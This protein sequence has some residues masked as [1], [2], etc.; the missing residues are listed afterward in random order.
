[1]EHV[2]QNVE[3]ADRSGPNLLT[4]EE[5]ALYD[6]V[7][8]A[9]EALC[10]IPC[11]DCKYCLPCPNGVAIPQVFEIYNELMMYGDENR[12]QMV[13]NWLAED[14]RANLCIEC[15]E[16][17]EKCPH[18]FIAPAPARSGWRQPGAPDRLRCPMPIAPGSSDRGY[19]WR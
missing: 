8:A 2:V 12:A 6:R 5:L 3:S 13:Y 10:P 16:C 19:T 11:T 9:Y 1:M 17:L 18:A 15:G 7:R 4:E 14:E